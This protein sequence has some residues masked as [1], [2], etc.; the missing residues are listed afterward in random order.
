MALGMESIKRL[1]S[2]ENRKSQLLFLLDGVVI[3]GAYVITTGTILSGYAIYLGAGDFLTTILNNS[4]N[5]ATILS[6]LSFVIFERMAKRKKTLLLLNFISRL[7]ICSTVLLPLIF[8]SKNFIFVLLTVMIIVSESIWGIYRVGWLVWMMEVVP[9]ESKSQYIY[10]RT[11]LLRLFMSIIAVISGFVLDIFNKGYIGFL[12]VF[13]FS[14][15]LS[16][17]DLGILKKVKDTECVVSK[18]EKVS[19]RMFSQPILHKE[20]RNFLFFTLFF[21]LGVTMATSFTPI[22]LIRYLKLDYKFI[23]TIN[24]ISQMVM[25]VSSIYWAKVEKKSGFKYVMGISGIIAI[26][27]LLV[28]S[29]LQRNTYYLLYLSTIISGIGM[30]GFAV[31]TFTYRYELMPRTGRTI[32]EGWYYFAYG[33]GMLIAPFSGKLLMECLPVFTNTIYKNSNIQ[34]LYLVAF[35]LLCFLFFTVFIRPLII[36]KASKHAGN[37]HFS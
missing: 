31:S 36:R 33:L 8:H 3:N 21:Y 9:K 19:F 6:L 17:L 35:F 16:L 10:M 28:L 27:E 24:V 15:A 14:F 13:S 30:G 20:Y 5:Y 1:C 37:E 32:Y 34:L 11:F 2:G 7:L 18:D 22:Y 26:G 12:V 4:T 23:S 29:F 25:V